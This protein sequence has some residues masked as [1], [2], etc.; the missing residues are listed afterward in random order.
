MCGTKKF[1]ARGGVL[2]DTLLVHRRC[3][4]CIILVVCTKYDQTCGLVASWPCNV[5][6]VGI[7]SQWS[8]SVSRMCRARGAGG[9]NL[10]VLWSRE[11]V[12]R[13]TYNTI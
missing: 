3:G 11:I 4:G 13:T 5:K 9:V 6:Y 7:R 12:V 8:L 10:P 1:T 2:G